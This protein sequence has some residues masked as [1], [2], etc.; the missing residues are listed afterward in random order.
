MEDDRMTQRF[1]AVITSLAVLLLAGCDNAS[2]RAAQPAPA[3]PLPQAEIT[4]PPPQ[5]A[6]PPPREVMVK[7]PGLDP[8]KLAQHAQ[9]LRELGY[10]AEANKLYGNA[11]DWGYAPACAQV[12]GSQAA[13][14]PTQASAVA[15]AKPAPAP[16]KAIAAAPA[17]VV[18]KASS[19]APVKPAAQGTVLASPAPAAPP[20]PAPVVAAPVP[21]AMPASP[22]PAPAPVVVAQIAPK[23]AVPAAEKPAPV[24]THKISQQAQGLEQMG[25]LPVAVKLYK[26]ACLAGDGQA[27]KRLG[28]IYIKGSDGVERDY[29]ES[30]RWYDRARHLGV[31]VPALEKRTVY[32]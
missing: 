4:P 6:P 21:A 29:A 23:P 1:T 3:T 20:T 12:S 10:Q 7:P 18:A 16:A 15:A 30:V 25:Y 26:D 11:C 31:V 9:A 13:P 27:C 24:D 2:D 32:R 17:P 28:E 19:P 8:A 22:P 14:K 5:P